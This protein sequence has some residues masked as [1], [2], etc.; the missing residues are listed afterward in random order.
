MSVQSDAL[1]IYYLLV[2]EVFM[3]EGDEK[4]T[5]IISFCPRGKDFQI[6]M[7]NKWLSDGVQHFS[8]TMINYCQEQKAE[9]VDIFVVV[10]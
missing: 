2:L 8:C 1:F 9:K 6:T 4:V 7:K 10:H 3:L 5:I